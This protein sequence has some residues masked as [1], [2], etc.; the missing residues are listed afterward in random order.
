[1][2]AGSV[3]KL[4][5]KEF[6][7]TT[8]CPVPGP[9]SPGPKTEPPAP[10]PNLSPAVRSRLLLGMGLAVLTVIIV[11]GLFA[12]FWGRTGSP[13][14][15][16]ALARDKTVPPIAATA[17]RSDQER[18]QGRWQV[19]ELV[20]ASTK[21]NVSSLMPVWEFQGTRLTIH[22]LSS[23]MDATLFGSFSLSTGV[24]RKLFDFSYTGTDGQPSALVGIYEF[25][26]E[27]LRVCFVN[28]RDPNFK[29]PDSFVAEPGTTRRYMKYRRLGDR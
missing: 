21:K 12:I 9:R 6:D 26:G 1:M 13:T 28:R 20:R 17:P 8:R 3:K 5:G 24:E 4:L 7:R 25:E 14:N 2:L 22:G 29:R 18:I 19:V 23:G 16:A 11:A 10:Q 15:E 27:F